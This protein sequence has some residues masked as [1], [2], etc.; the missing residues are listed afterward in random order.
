MKSYPL[1]FKEVSKIF[2]GDINNNDKNNYTK[3]K[4]HALREIDL[5][6]KNNSFNLILGPS[7]SG[8]ST[9][10]FLASL[11]DIPTSGEII[12]NGEKTC[13]MSKSERSAMRRTEIG[14]VYQRN[15]L[16]PYLNILENVSVPMVKKDRD[17]ALK[18]LENTGL[19]DI[20]RFPAD[21][22]SADQQ[23]VALTR[24]VINNP[25]LILADEPTGEL[26]SEDAREIIRLLK[27]F[28]S[29]CAVLVA[30]DN[31]DLSNYADNIFYIADGIL[32]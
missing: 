10:L 3:N 32:K 25:S 12:I 4:T 16:F 14:I 31:P 24:A 23:K 27:D 22:S 11:L 2:G 7:G 8:K 13:E 1:E 21:I 6:I 28:G 19:K 18:L 17:K 29:K 20:K 9:L 30:S 5:Q 15:N 26:N